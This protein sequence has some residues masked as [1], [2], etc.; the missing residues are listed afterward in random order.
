MGQRNTNMLRVLF[1]LASVSLAVYAAP[2]SEL[3][4]SEYEYL[5]KA[6][7]TDHAKTYAEHQTQAKFRVFRD[8]VDFIND[9]NKNHADTLGYTVGI[10][11]FADMTKTEYK[12][13]MLGYNALRKP[14]NL[15]TEEL[16]ET[17]APAS[18]DWTTKGA[19]TPV[20]NQGQCGSCWAF[21]TT[22][23][24]EGRNQIKNGKLVSLSEQELTSC[25]SK[26]GN[27]GCN[28]GLMDDASSSSRPKVLRLR[29]T[30][31]TMVPLE[32][33][34]P[35]RRRP[36]MASTMVFSLLDTALMVART[37]GR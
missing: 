34:T 25:A 14:T 1:C 36:M 20:K 24:V 22:G 17:A 37:T 19:V 6:F 11:Q 4:V 35:R 33:V 32:P 29:L 18:V 15:V 16:D 10:N 13:T 3:S 23:S 2:Q 27:Q 5:F 9:H 31:N 21:S 26:Y 7:Q 30:T 12:R 8:N 28:G